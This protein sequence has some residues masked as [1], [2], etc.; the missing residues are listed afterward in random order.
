MARDLSFWRSS[1]LHVLNI[2]GR[3]PQVEFPK[4]SQSF[5]KHHPNISFCPTFFS[6]SKVLVLSKLLLATYKM[7]LS[8]HHRSHRSVYT[9][10]SLTVRADMIKKKKTHPFMS[11]HNFKILTASSTLNLKATL[12]LSALFSQGC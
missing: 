4:P 12:L 5:N 11:V 6:I 3:N 10:M 2:F 9:G 7:Y 1:F 8:L